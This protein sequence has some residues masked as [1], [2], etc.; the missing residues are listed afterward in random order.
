M[1]KNTII[2]L[3][4]IFA[5]IFGFNYFN[6]PSEEELA[7][8]QHQRDSIAQ[9]EALHEQ[10]KAE[11]AKLQPVASPTSAQ[12]TGDSALT[13]IQFGEFSSVATGDTTLVE[14][15]NSL[16]KYR[17]SPEGGRIER[18]ILKDYKRYDST[19][20]VL[21]DQK[22]NQF[23]L[24]LVT[25]SNRVINTRALY[26]TPELKKLEDG[27]QIL[28]MRLP[29]AEDSYLDYV[30][31]IYPENYMIDFNIVSHNMQNY[32]SNR[33]VI[34]MEWS[35][36]VR[37][38]EKGRVFESRYAR[39][40]Y[41]FTSDDV[42]RLSDSKD[43]DE[44]PVGKIKWMAFK[45]QFFSSILVGDDSFDDVTLK[46][47][48]EEQTSNYIKDYNMKAALP[49]E[50]VGTQITK[51]HY[52]FGPNHYQT[53]RSYDKGKDKDEKLRMTKIIPL[54]SFSLIRYVNQIA[55]IPMFNF[56]GRF[57]DN[58]GIIILLMTIAIKL[59]L[60]P[61]TYKSYMSTAKMRVLRPQIE[62]INEKIPKEKALERQQATQA[63][64]KKVGVSPMGGCLPMV[65]QMPILFAMF[66]FFPTAIELRQ[67]GFLWA[68]DLSSYDAILTWQANIPIISSVFGN[69]LSL[70]CLLMTITNLVYTKINMANNPSNSSIKGMNYIMYLM[71][72]MF[73]FMFNN[74][75]SGLSYYYFISL[76]F[77]ILQ[78]YMFR[79]FTD[80]DK[81]LAQLEVKKGKN[82]ANQGSKPKKKSGF[83]ARLE[84][85]QREQQKRLDEQRKKK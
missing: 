19:A 46:S 12:M 26:F 20:I 16:A 35:T 78:T 10:D 69:H 31:T 39:L 6:R 57:I 13:Q 59:V 52:Y 25:V 80:D 63:L 77:T 17:F 48:P 28:T 38:Q 73:L 8:M 40:Y 55:I 4:L 21:F 66:R 7:V 85:A 82:K 2:G 75:A 3:V 18:V 70:F 9:V 47:H 34:D 56:F 5:V 62:A 84:A 50:A 71:P 30:Y 49:F 44:S 14:L 81:L 22:D 67:Q 53:L 36:K 24:Q 45:D 65:L 32:I 68:H 43:D 72:L 74:Y 51:M 83:M 64:Y 76:L 42:E 60:L 11:R 54:G 61:F 23:N 29:M 41:K 37:H 58:Y 27:T 1:D 79:W 33:G 15:E